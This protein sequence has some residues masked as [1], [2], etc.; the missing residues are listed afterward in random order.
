MTS[1]YDSNDMDAA[2]AYT[3]QI[4]VLFDAGDIDAA[5]ALYMADPNGGGN[6]DFAA[7]TK[8]DLIYFMQSTMGGHFAA[9][10]MTSL[11]RQAWAESG[12]S[13]DDVETI[14]EAGGYAKIMAD[15]KKQ[16][17]LQD[18]IDHLMQ[19]RLINVRNALRAR[20]WQ[21]PDAHTLLSVIDLGSTPDKDV[22]FNYTANF[23]HV[24]AGKNVVGMK[25]HV[26]PVVSHRETSKGWECREFHF[27]EVKD[28]MKMPA[29]QVADTLCAILPCA[30]L[31][32]AMPKGIG[33]GKLKTLAYDQWIDFVRSNAGPETQAGLHA[34]LRI[35]PRR[36]DMEA[37]E[38]ARLWVD[39]G[40][41]AI[42]ER[43]NVFAKE[44]QFKD[45]EALMFMDLIK[46]CVPHY[47]VPP[48]RKLVLKNLPKD[49]RVILTQ[50]VQDRGYQVDEAIENS[51]LPV[52]DIDVAQYVEQVRC[53]PWD[54]RGY[55]HVATMA[56]DYIL[57]GLLPPIVIENGRWLDG[58]HRL[59]A[60][61]IADKKTLKA[62]D[63]TVW[64]KQSLENGLMTV[65]AEA[66]QNYLVRPRGADFISP[67]M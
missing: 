45:Y 2:I 10:Y 65:D 25:H 43:F 41:E 63:L 35:G 48:E 58:R 50:F 5:Y 56:D 44:H 34:A 29:A 49:M 23:A 20:G 6:A 28:D 16:L 46:R 31:L 30:E 66:E 19:Q 7:S 52:S 47:G 13:H 62:I 60:A 32:R 59:L 8:E 21:G 24:G 55:A 1:P 51:V 57:G 54:E 40:P 26:L 4:R 18:M 27:L 33:K 42:N 14:A 53:E 11:E 17:Q 36:A 64:I 38:L 15:T 22:T 39:R 9:T 67:D 3:R 37:A 12:A 61:E